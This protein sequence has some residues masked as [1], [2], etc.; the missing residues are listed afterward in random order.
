MVGRIHQK[1][2]TMIE[3]IMA[4]VI[5]SVLG[6]FLFNFLGD[7]MDVYMTTK[8]QKNLH[9]EALMAMERMVREIR[10]AKVVSIP[11]DYT[12]SITKSHP[13]GE[14]ITFHKSGSTLYRTYNSQDFTLAQDVNSF[15][16]TES[17][18]LITLDLTLSNEGQVRLR[19]KVQAR[20]L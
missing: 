11:N 15:T 5:M 17:S 1:G 3:A 2:F 13:D 20:N 19:S 9:D 16:V 8:R 7:G 12:I 6:L 10:D 14:S 4:M 18:S